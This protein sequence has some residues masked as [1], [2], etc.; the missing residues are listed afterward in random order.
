MVMRFVSRRGGPTGWH[1]GPPRLGLDG[2]GLTEGGGWR[3]LEQRSELL[4]GVSASR[5]RVEPGAL[6]RRRLTVAV[7]ALAVLAVAYAV[8]EA[9][10]PVTG[11]TRWLY[12]IHDDVYLVLKGYL[13]TALFPASFVVL[14]LALAILFLALQHYLSERPVLLTLWLAWL[15]WMAGQAPV[16]GWLVSSHRFAV[17]HGA[18]DH[19]LDLVAYAAQRE[20]LMDVVWGQPE[21]AAGCAR[22][23]GL[24]ALRMRLTLNRG[25][26]PLPSGERA[27][28][29]RL[30]LIKAKSLTFRVRGLFL[31]SVER[32]SRKR[33]APSPQPSPR[34][35]PEQGYEPSKIAGLQAQAS[36]E[37]AFPLGRGLEA[38]AIAVETMAAE[39]RTPLT[40]SRLD[41]IVNA[42]KPQ[43]DEQRPPFDSAALLAELGVLLEA[44]SPI[45]EADEA[46]L[47]ELLGSV[48]Q[49][50]TA[51][52]RQIERWLPPLQ[53]ALFFSGRIGS[54]L[55]MEE[56]GLEME[57]APFAARLATDLAFR[58]ALAFDDP[59]I[60]QTW[61]DG[62]DALR[63][64]LESVLES[65]PDDDSRARFLAARP[66]LMTLER[67]TR[68][69]PGTFDHA[70]L[71]RLLADQ[72]EEGR[73]AVPRLSGGPPSLIRRRFGED[74]VAAARLAGG[75]R[76]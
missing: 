55:G 29:Q 71:A 43:P 25:A 11:A 9:L 49:R 74:A 45:Q 36:G 76:G 17:R 37:R 54:D 34:S 57:T 33:Q 22:L 27:E 64:A 51:R 23:D 56:S 46:R 4:Q 6:A 1:A 53:E 44:A 12:V 59:A 7:V 47:F 3:R 67:F 63:L 13:F 50:I 61:I 38:A 66:R 39:G 2:G 24:T 62:L 15:R 42:F 70:R 48:A 14:L 60:A 18:E 73:R 65:L 10:L 32:L 5:R 52:R 30:S 16:Q 35:Y 68:H 19:A 20:A 58:L 8:G 31:P 28:S 26:S 21:A 75:L 41:E 72:A 40:R 69:C